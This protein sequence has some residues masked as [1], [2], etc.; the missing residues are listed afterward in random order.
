LPV[1]EI[2]FSEK[3]GKYYL[4]FKFYGKLKKDEAAEAIKIWDEYFL[5][6]KNRKIIII[7]HCLEMT[8]YEKG[9]REIWQKTLKKMSNKIEGIWVITNSSVI[10]MGASLISL[11][12]AYPIK[13][14]STEDEIYDNIKNNKMVE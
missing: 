11:F 10:R 5:K 12:A 3:F 9:A 6:N 4:K 13:I 8:G 14:V 1:P 2:E 7:W